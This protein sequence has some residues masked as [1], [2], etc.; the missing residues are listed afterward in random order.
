MIAKFKHTPQAIAYVCDAIASSPGSGQVQLS[1]IVGGG[2]FIG[3]REVPR[4]KLL[5]ALQFECRQFPEATVVVGDTE[6][7]DTFAAIQCSCQ[8]SFRKHCAHH[9]EHSASRPLMLVLTAPESGVSR[10]RILDTITRAIHVDLKAERHRSDS[11]ENENL[12]HEDT[13]KRHEKQTHDF[14]Q[15]MKR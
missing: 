5:D 3:T 10:H 12:S 14:E 6:R 4:E 11:C 13:E 15:W 7:G 9:C 8:T 1:A 2:Y